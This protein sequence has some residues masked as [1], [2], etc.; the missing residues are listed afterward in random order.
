MQTIFILIL[1]TCQKGFSQSLKPKR[2]KNVPTME[3]LDDSHVSVDYAACFDIPD[4]SQIRTASVL[5]LGSWYN[6]G[7]ATRDGNQLE[8][9]VK[10]YQNLTQDSK[11]K[12]KLDPCKPHSFVVRLTFGD[13]EEYVD[14]FPSEYVNGQW[15]FP[16]RSTIKF[17]IL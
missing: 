8:T 1:V 10:V 14:S 3:V 16:V 13:P 2:T 15:A 9:D 11:L 6:H 12:V 4:F 17:H 5:V 7:M